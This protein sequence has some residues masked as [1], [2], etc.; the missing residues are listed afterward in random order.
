M[1]IRPLG[2]EDW[3]VW[4][5]LRLEALYTVPEAFGSSFKEESMWSDEKFKEA[6][7]RNAILGVFID[8]K[9][10][11]SICF[12]ILDS[13]KKRHIGVIWGMYVRSDHRG[14]GVAKSLLKGVI[15]H[16]RGRVLQ[17]HLGVVTINESAVK[18]YQKHGFNI[19]GTELR[20]FKIG[21]RF[22]DEYL[23]V[24]LSA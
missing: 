16:A 22:Y 11:G 6:L 10:I 19:Y 15:N 21:D 13:L 3:K 14:K 4:K 12:S 7:I 8:E 17:V 2:Q 9:L 23:M 5:E 18:L 24:L 20:S 1:M